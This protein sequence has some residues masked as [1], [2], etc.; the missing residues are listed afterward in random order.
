MYEEDSDLTDIENSITG[1]PKP[2]RGNAKNK[3]SSSYRVTNALKPPRTT[4]YTAKSLYDQMYQGDIDVDPEYQRDVVW[5]DS[6]QM[7]IIDSM[8]RN[9]YVPPIIFAVINHDDGSERRVCIDG[10]QRLTSIQKFM[11]GEIPHKDPFSNEKLWFKDTIKKKGKDKLLPERYVTLFQNKQ[12]VCVEYSDLTSADEREIFKRVQLG[13]ALMTGERLKGLQGPLPTLVRKVIELYLTEDGLSA[14]KYIDW[15]RSRGREFQTVAQC[16]LTIDKYPSFKSVGTAA[17]VEKWL[18]QT[19]EPDEDFVDKVHDTFRIFAGLVQDTKLNKV[20]K[21]PNPRLAPVEFILISLLISVH[22]QR[23]SREKLA[24]AIG[25]MRR[26]LRREHKDIRTNST[27]AKSGQDFVKGLKPGQVQGEGPPAG[28]RPGTMGAGKRKRVAAEDG[29]VS[30][31]DEEEDI[32]LKTQR[33]AKTKLDSVNGKFPYKP[34]APAPAPAPAPTPNTSRANPVTSQTILGNSGSWAPPPRLAAL[35]AAKAISSTA[36]SPGLSSF[37]SSAS[38]SKPGIQSP[39]QA[40]ISSQHHNSSS[41][42]AWGEPQLLQQ[43]HGSNPASPTSSRNSPFTQ[44]Q[45]P[46]PSTNRSSVESGL[47]GRMRGSADQAGYA[48]RTQQQP[49]SQPSQSYSQPHGGSSISISQLNGRNQNS[50]PLH[51]LHLPPKPQT[52]TYPNSPLSASSTS[53]APPTGPAAYR[54]ASASASDYVESGPSSSNSHDSQYGFD[55]NHRRR[56]GDTSGS[57][58]HSAV[59]YPKFR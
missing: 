34:P 24:S 38:V 1:S 4:S 23:F 13:M 55:Q 11:D 5:P 52:Q 54:R 47:M 8:F 35:K 53:F 6:K 3:S 15:D 44:N 59:G 41:Q 57:G 7:G 14:D 9:F 16:L 20:F 40:G 49:Y 39:S 58:G 32:P 45:L 19:E 46:T 42:S 25:L 22:K 18:G 33:T 2:G 10:K 48:Q 29:E 28:A 21:Q 30:E 31:D 56:N 37:S 26:E 51:P 36:E 12:V 50:H 17:Q 43:A 27:V